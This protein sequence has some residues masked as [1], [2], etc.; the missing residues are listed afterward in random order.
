MQQPGLVPR[1]Q[2]IDD[3]RQQLDLVPVVQLLNPI[4]EQRHER[5]DSIAERRQA[6]RAD[7]VDSAFR[8]HERALPVVVAVDHHEDDA[9]VEIA[10]QS[11]RVRA[12]SRNPHPQ[13][14]NGR[15]EV[16]DGQACLRAHD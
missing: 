10:D 13:D 5:P 4:A 9:G 7:V 16:L 2:P 11:F 3:Y 14:V 6:A 12:L 8:D 15:A 1:S